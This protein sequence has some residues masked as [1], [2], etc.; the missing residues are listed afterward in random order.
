MKTSG[1]DPGTRR[2][3]ASGSDPVASYDEFKEYE[4][5]KYTGMKIGRSH[6]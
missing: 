1:R 3:K 6:Q 4:G 2:G 5:R